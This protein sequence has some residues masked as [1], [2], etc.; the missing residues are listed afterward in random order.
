MYK[1]EMDEMSPQF[2]GLWQAALEHLNRQVQGGLETWLR[3]HSAP[4][5]PAHLSFRLGN[6]NF[7][8]RVHDADGRVEGPGRMRGL[9]HVAKECGGHACILPMRRK[10]LSG[11]WQPTRPAWGLVD[12]STGNTVDPFTLVTDERIPMTPWEIHS[13]GMQVVVQ[14]LEQ[15]GFEV[16]MF[17]DDPNIDPTLWF[18]NKHGEPEWVVV[19]TVTYPAKRAERPSNWEKLSENLSP[20]AKTGH[21]ASVSLSSA[22]LPFEKPDEEPMPLWRG[23]GMYARFEG[24][25]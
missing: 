16:T 8:S 23:H 6:Q 24:L 7:F 12:A 22:D 10:G 3:Y 21:F 14:H 15:E 25:E 17:Q 2:Y 18:Q 11:S 5:F 1:I 20:V 9:K 4:P 13:M 19:R